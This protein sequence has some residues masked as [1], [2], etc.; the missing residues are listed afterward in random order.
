MRDIAVV[1][2]LALAFAAARTVGQL[3][4]D[5]GGSSG[6]GGGGGGGG[7]FYVP[8]CFECRNIFF[9]F[10]HCDGDGGQN[11]GGGEGMHPCP[12]VWP[13]SCTSEHTTE[14][15]MVSATEFDVQHYAGGILAGATDIGVC[16]RE[17]VAR[18]A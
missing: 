17:S 7:G 15:E 18:I 6:G 12:E 16:G 14:C 5:G 1:V 13:G 3:P 9:G 11:V 2:M 10:W 4:S 8:D